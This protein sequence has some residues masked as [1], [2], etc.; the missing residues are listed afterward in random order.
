MA[1]KVASRVRGLSD[2]AF[3]EAFGTKE[4]CRAALVRRSSS[5]GRTTTDAGRACQPRIPGSP[6]SSHRT[7]QAG[8]KRCAGVHATWHRCHV[9]G[10]EP[11]CASVVIPAA[12]RDLAA[13]CISTGGTTLSCS[14]WRRNTGG[15]GRPASDGTRPP[16]SAPE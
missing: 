7:K 4:Q 12:P 1:F 6:A 14:P 10:P 11:G 15:G 2:E 3:R 5:P 8:Q 13:I 9:P 16:A